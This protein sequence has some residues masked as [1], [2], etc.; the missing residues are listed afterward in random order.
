MRFH[1]CKSAAFSRK[2]EGEEETGVTPEKE[3][4]KPKAAILRS[5]KDKMAKYLGCLSD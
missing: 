5:V 4:K 2:N 3:R 1:P